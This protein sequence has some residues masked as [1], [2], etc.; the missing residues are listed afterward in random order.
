MNA[1][2][3]QKIL[4]ASDKDAKNYLEKSYLGEDMT[5][6]QISDLLGISQNNVSRLCIK[7]GIKALQPYERF[8][9]SK[10]TSS[11][12][13]IIYGM[14]MSDGNINLQHKNPRIRFSQCL[15]NKEFLYFCYNYLKDYISG[16]IRFRKPNICKS[17]GI[18]INSSGRYTFKTHC[19]PMFIDIYNDFYDKNKKKRLTKNIFSKEIFTP[20]MLAVWFM[21][22][23]CSNARVYVS[24]HTENFTY[25]EHQVMVK[26]FQERFKLNPTIRLRGKHYILSFN[27]VDSQKFIEIVKP[28]I[29]PSMQYKILPITKN[30]WLKQ[31]VGKLP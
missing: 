12:Q 25:Q 31:N 4:Y 27:V 11:Q 30:E 28:Y 7:F 6:Q 9:Y 8:T 5:Q 17:R 19:H 21:G 29:V 3:K 13:Q 2:Y 14:I 10:L 22:D 16:S 20:L 15:A 24:L 23:G 18:I 26:A 1:L